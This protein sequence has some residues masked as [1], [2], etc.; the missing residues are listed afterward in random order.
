MSVTGLTSDVVFDGGVEQD[1]PTLMDAAFDR[2]SRSI[3]RYVAVRVGDAHLADDLLQQTWLQ[4]HASDARVSSEKLESWL[5]SIAKNLVRNHWRRR[6]R[7]PAGVPL[8]DAELAGELAERLIS[9]ELPSEILERREIR[10]Q[11]LLA[12]TEL[13]HREQELIVE[14]Y[15]HGRA[16]AELAELYDLSVRGVEGQLYRARHSLRNKLKHLSVE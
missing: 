10:D 16:Q 14:H 12:V 2:C 11:L 8:P 1:D 7:R 15:F 9:E 13:P 5:W 6:I 3:Y 4:A